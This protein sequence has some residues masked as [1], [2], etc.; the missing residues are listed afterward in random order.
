MGRFW[1][2]A[3]GYDFGSFLL[4]LLFEEEGLCCWLDLGVGCKSFVR[5]KWGLKFWR[6][7]VG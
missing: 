7:C 4:L 1:E 3:E 6:C 5:V 2:R